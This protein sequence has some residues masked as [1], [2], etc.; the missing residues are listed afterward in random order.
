MKKHRSE[1]KSSDDDESN[2]SNS[3]NNN[4]SNQVTG[5]LRCHGRASIKNKDIINDECILVVY[6]LC[7]GCVLVYIVY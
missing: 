7:I 4:N 6:W 1:S 5:T 2:S 3:N